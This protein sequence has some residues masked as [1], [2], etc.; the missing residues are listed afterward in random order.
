M[1]FIL[2]AVDDELEQAGHARVKAS[3]RVATYQT[4]RV[5]SRLAG[6]SPGGWARSPSVPI[7]NMLQV[8]HLYS[9]PHF[10]KPRHTIASL[11]PRV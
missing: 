6:A 5:I 7:V 2:P 1:G 9:Q 11:P 3:L 10:F 4:P 8:R